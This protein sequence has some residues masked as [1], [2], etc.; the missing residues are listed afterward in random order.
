MKNAITVNLSDYPKQTLP[1]MEVDLNGT[2]ITHMDMTNI[3]YLHEASILYNL[4][5]RYE[6][7]DGVPYTRT[8]DIIIAINPY[9]WIKGLYAQAAREFYAEQLVWRANPRARTQLPPHLYEASALAFKGLIMG[10][11]DQSILVSGESGAGKTVAVKIL[12]SHLA[13]FH[14]SRKKYNDELLE[15]AISNDDNGTYGI[16]GSIVN[17]VVRSLLGVSLLRGQQGSMDS[18]EDRGDLEAPPSEPD[19]EPEEM[20]QTNLIVKRVLDSNPLLEAFGNAKTCR[21]DNSSRFSKYVKLQFHLEYLSRAFPSCH[22]AGSRCET[23]LLEKSRVVSHASKIGERTFHIFYQLLAAPEEFK[24][25]IWS[26]L[27]GKDASSFNYVGHNDTDT[28]EG[29][30]DAQRWRRTIFALEILGVRDDKLMTLLRA[31]CAVLQ[32]GNL[33]FSADPTNDDAS[34]ISSKDELEKLSNIIGIPSDDI[35]QALTHRSV[36][37]AADDTTFKVHMNSEQAKD[38]CDAFAKEIYSNIFEWL[39]GEINDATCAENNFEKSPG[40]R[41][42]NIGLLDIFGFECFEVNQFEQLCINHANEKLQQKFTSDIFCTVKDEYDAE[43]IVLREILYTDNT[44]ILN[45]L[46]KKCGIIDLLN[47]ECVRPRGSDTGFVN[48][49]YAHNKD[50]DIPLVRNRRYQRHEF[51]VEHYAGIVKYDASMIVAKN[52]DK[53]S[54]DVVECGVKSSNELIRSSLE[55]RKRDKQEKNKGSLITNTV[56]TKFKAQLGSLMDCIGQTKTRYV[57]CINPNPDKTPG[58]LDLKY[59]VFQLR[60]AGIVSAV[61]MSRAAFPNRLTYQH[62][63]ERFR[64]LAE[65]GIQKEKNFLLDV[66]KS[67]DARE[68][69]DVKALLSYLLEPLEVVSNSGEITKAFVCGNTRVYFRVGALEHL[70]SERLTAYDRFATKIQS[71]VRRNKAVQEYR[72]L[73][74]NPPPKQIRRRDGLIGSIF[75]NM[76]PFL[77]IPFLIMRQV[78]SFPLWI[79][80][81]PFRRRRN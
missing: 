59:S 26:G 17:W 5:E 41:F 33:T 56:W 47:E 42:G 66:M 19:D 52:M 67:A 58:V 38:T 16:A 55:A 63:L 53:L 51:A 61:T 30:T 68:K 80:G 1:L 64:F 10:S 46:E 22:I 60:C 6:G 24:A 73:A 31:L 8:G 9:R 45:L 15:D 36:T 54:E 23:Y 57:R 77:P 79:I 65:M 34:V 70:E 75:I 50:P 3:P 43:G 40:G 72:V 69:Q 39:V 2:P 71:R 21:N 12:M 4:K 18:E 25:R 78:V 35:V 11:Q 20:Q 74:K 32:L 62:I 29:L 37:V 81:H 76:M 13:T 48:K 49:L 44:N 27:E 7:R 28:I 14:E